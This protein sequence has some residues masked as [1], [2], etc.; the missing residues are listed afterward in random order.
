MRP[1]RP[2]TG[3]PAVPWCARHHPGAT[4]HRRSGGDVTCGYAG[5]RGPGQCQSQRGQAHPRHDRESGRAGGT[6]KPI[7]L[8]SNSRRIRSKRSSMQQFIRRIVLL[9]LVIGKQGTSRTV[10]RAWRSPVGSAASLVPASPANA[11]YPV[12][13][14]HRLGHW[15]AWTVAAR[16]LS[17]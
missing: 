4:G 8:P 16:S 7:L 17:W 14:P 13:E 15:D 11:V 10:L 2:P 9:A 3:K 5:S 1:F 6:S 12:A